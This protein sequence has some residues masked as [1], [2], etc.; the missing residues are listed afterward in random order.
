MRYEGILSKMATMEIKDF[1]DEEL[2]R[3]FRD[4]IAPNLC[5]LLA[6]RMI[7]D[8]LTIEEIME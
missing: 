2:R 8:G 7:A 4:C 5:T 3:V 6:R 1:S